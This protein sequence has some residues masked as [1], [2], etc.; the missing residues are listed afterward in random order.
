MVRAGESRDHAGRVDPPHPVALAARD[1][2]IARPVHRHAN[3]V[4]QSSPDR[5]AAVAAEAFLPRAG[6]S[7]DHAGRV[8]PPHPV[9]P[10]VRDVQIARSVH[11]HARGIGQSSPDRRAAVAAEAFLPRAGDGGDRP[12]GI[13]L[14]N[15]IVAGIGDVEVACPVRRH[16]QKSIGTDIEL[17]LGR[18][19]AV[20]AEAFLPRAGESR[21]HAGRVDPP[22]SVAR[23][24]RG[25]HVSRPVHRHARGI[26][27]SSLDRRTAVPA[28]AFLPRAGDGGNRPRGIDSTNAIVAGIR[29][30][31]IAR[32]VRRHARGVVQSSLDCRAAVAAEA[33]LARAG[34]SRDHAGCVDP[35]HPVVFR[36][37]D[38]HVARPVRRHEQKSIVADIEMGLD[39][40]AAVPDASARKRVDFIAGRR[41]RPGSSSEKRDA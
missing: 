16:E 33:A 22:H 4:G 36:V 38:V 17:G 24:A 28:E 34:E 13:D 25:V 30:V 11:R 15:A 8:D 21:D 39:R 7:R 18:Q 6:E 1:V 27:Q 35:P 23:V 9:V 26:G 2:Q 14:S 12:C 20:A 40:R 32:P 31:Q 37:C 10:R 29:D 19:P 5:R 41:L 3:G